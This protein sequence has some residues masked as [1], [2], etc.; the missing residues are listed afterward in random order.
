MTAYPRSP[1]VPLDTPGVD[2]HLCRGDE[3]AFTDLTVSTE[4]MFCFSMVPIQPLSIHQLKTSLY[5]F[6][7]AFKKQF[8]I[9]MN[10]PSRFTKGLIAV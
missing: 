3:Q 4:I 5:D 9:K 6:L 7:I 10:R 1:P 8:A 2:T